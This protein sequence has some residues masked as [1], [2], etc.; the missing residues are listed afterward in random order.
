M[1]HICDE[2]GCRWVSNDE[3]ERLMQLKKDKEIV[4]NNQVNK[5]KS[6]FERLKR[7]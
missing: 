3:Y 7:K 1:K 2:N 5:K 6:L 4:Q